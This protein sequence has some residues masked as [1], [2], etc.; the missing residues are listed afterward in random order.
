MIAAESTA[1]TIN[2]VGAIRVSSVKQ[3][4][5]GDSPEAQKEQIEQ[6]AQNKGFNIKKFFVFM[7]SASKEQQPMQEAIDYCKDPNNQ[8]SHFIIKSIDRF[9]RGGS[10]PYDL[11]KN[12]LETSKVKLID[13]YGIIGSNQVNTLEHLGVEYRWSVYSPSKKSEILEAERSKDE[14]RDI[15]T[16]M[17]GAEVR[18]TRLGYWMRRPPYGYASQK[19]HTDHGKRTIL[20]PHP[21]ESKFIIEIFRLRSLGQYSDKE[22]A[23]KIN[24]MGYLGRIHPSD[25]LKHTSLNASKVW[26]IVRK[27]I[28]TGINNEKWTNNQPV[29]CVFKGLVSIETFNKA[30]KGRRIIRECNGEIIIKDT[31][32]ERYSTRQGTR[33]QDFPYKQFVMCP[34]CELPLSGS[35]SRGKSGK[36]YPAYH[37]NRQGHYFRVRKEKLE[38]KVH[39]L[40]LSLQLSPKHVDKLTH[41]LESVF[42]VIEQQ[43]QAKLSSLDTRISSVENEIKAIVNKFKILTNQFAIKHLENDLEELEQRLTLLKSKKL[44]L[45]KQKPFNLGDFATKLKHVFEHLDKSFV[46]QMSEAKKAKLFSLLFNKLPTYD[47]L[48]FRTPKDPIFT[49]VNPLFSIKNSNLLRLVTPGGI[50]PPF[51]G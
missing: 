47:K 7:E 22:I 40:I 46:Q 9:T 21:D 25:T 35:Y 30:N 19:I 24:E 15:M 4:L 38:D 34:K 45:A 50:E 17:V 12:Q 26:R 13:I 42:K 1:K 33:S 18:Y 27:P 8:I 5:K 3:G 14:L 37:C 44:E 16:R 28:Y 23:N 43:Y 51:P 10:L 49:D 41:S 6:F 48:E 31:K 2:A 36:R 39:Q 20:V 29:K 32:A 11:L